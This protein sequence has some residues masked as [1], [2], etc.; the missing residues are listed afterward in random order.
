MKHA[1]LPLLSLACLCAV[2]FAACGDDQVRQVGPAIRVVS[3]HVDADGGRLLD[4][5]P[6]PVLITEQKKLLIYNDGL[7]P[8]TIHGASIATE[9]DAFRIDPLGPTGL[10][11]EPG[12]EQELIVYFQ[13]PAQEEFQGTL[14]LE[15]DDEDTGPVPVELIGTGSTVG[16]IEVSPR[17]LDFGR[18]GERTQE[19][20][21]VS[22]R[23]VG[24][25]R[26][27]I[28]SIELAGAPA[29]SLLG[30]TSTPAELAAPDG[31]TPGG[32][33]DLLVACSPTEDLEE[34]SLAGTLTIRSTDP[35]NREI[36]VD[37]SATV[38][39]APV[40]I[41]G[42]TGGGVP[43]PGDS[44]ALD[45]SGSHDTDGDDPVTFF[46]RVYRKP[47]G[48]DASIDDPEA[49]RPSLVTD[50]AGTY[51]IGLD[52]ADSTGLSCLH[53]N[54]DPMIPCATREIVVKP[55]DDLYFEL[56]WDHPDTD[57]DLHLLDRGAALYSAR[58]CYHGNPAPDFGEFGNALDDPRH[59]RDDLRGFGPERVIYSKP[60][61]GTFEVAVV[62]AKTNGAAEPAT[63]ATV[64]V[65]V[66]G[67]LEAEMSAEL[68]TKDQVWRVLQLTWP[69]AGTSPETGITPVDLI[70]DPPASETQP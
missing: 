2:A 68:D 48:S 31:G 47:L 13:P 24:T 41:I 44:V 32:A 63:N 5:G 43:A 62:F 52:V 51:V 3:T 55:S 50:M 67:V 18:V 42:E 25:A 56:V 53:P 66:Y 38:N 64:R 60:P 34:D 30:S 23:S 4:Y 9:G 15:H 12:A 69:D 6:V 17:Q 11:L 29:F 7:A 10:R 19:V 65:F 36:V 45:G 59:T 28:E 57:L 37:L 40:A 20:R 16:R 8:L 61:A 58:D 27:I 14:T 70:E 39:R 49:A 22:I 21:T 26:L 46:W 35:E 33:V 1:V 54:D